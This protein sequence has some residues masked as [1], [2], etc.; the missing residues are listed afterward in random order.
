MLILLM[1]GA[2]LAGH[3]GLKVGGLA[4]MILHGE[5]PFQ[6]ACLVL[7]FSGWGR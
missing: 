5:E 4:D 3:F 2:W 1:V 7:G 6:M